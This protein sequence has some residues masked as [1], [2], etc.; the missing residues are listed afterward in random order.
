MEYIILKLESDELLK[1]VKGNAKDQIFYS[2]FVVQ[3]VEWLGLHVVE[4]EWR[5]KDN[6]STEDSVRESYLQT[7]RLPKI[8]SFLTVFESIA[9]AEPQH[10]SMMLLLTD[11]LSQV[12]TS[13]QQTRHLDWARAINDADFELSAIGMAL[14]DTAFMNNHAASWIQRA[15]VSMAQAPEGSF[16]WAATRL[17]ETR[18]IT[19]IRA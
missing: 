13:L 2:L 19:D 3:L 4:H 11:F 16:D 12:V 7:C 1:K 9:R 8:G 6:T 14:N 17:K 15:I 10:S 18:V 5:C